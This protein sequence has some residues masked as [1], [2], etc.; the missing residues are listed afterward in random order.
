M[1]KVTIVSVLL[2]EFEEIE[3]QEQK[4]TQMFI[5]CNTIMTF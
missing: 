3:G 1:F 5:L 4:G 2:L